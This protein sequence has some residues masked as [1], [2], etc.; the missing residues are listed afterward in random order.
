MEGRKQG[1]GK[2]GRA[3]SKSSLEEYERNQRQNFVD[4]WPWRETKPWKK[5][6]DFICKNPLTGYMEL[7]WRGI[8]RAR[9]IAFFLCK[10]LQKKTEGWIFNLLVPAELSSCCWTNVFLH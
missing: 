6:W 1:T 9:I 4:P 10:S 7:L 5:R 3:L 2:E 8:Q